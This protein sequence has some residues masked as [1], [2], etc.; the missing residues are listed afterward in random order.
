MKLG[1]QVYE[2]PVWGFIRSVRQ[3]LQGQLKLED[4]SRLD[5]FRKGHEPEHI[6]T[7]DGDRQRSGLGPG[8][9]LSEYEGG[10]LSPGED[11][12]H[13]LIRLTDRH[14]KHVGN[15]CFGA[16]LKLKS[17]S[18]ADRPWL[19]GE[20]EAESAAPL[21]KSRQVFLQTSWKE[22]Y[23][24]LARQLVP[25]VPVSVAV[26]SSHKD[27]AEV[28]RQLKG[29][30][31]TAKVKLH[32]V[33]CQQSASRTQ[34]G[35]EKKL[36]VK[37]FITD[38]ELMGSK[39]DAWIYVM[40][41]EV[42]PGSKDKEASHE[43]KHAR[44]L[45]KGLLKRDRLPLTI[46]HSLPALEPAACME[47]LQI[48]KDSNATVF[49]LPAEGRPAQMIPGTPLSP[50]GH[51]L[52]PWAAPQE[53]VKAAVP[54]L[55]AKVAVNMLV[56]REV[57][58]QL[59][60][61]KN[62]KATTV[63]WVGLSH[64]GLGI[65]VPL[66]PY[67]GIPLLIAESFTRMFYHVLHVCH[68]AGII[69]NLRDAWAILKGAI[70][71]KELEGLKR[72]PKLTK[73]ALEDA[74]KDGGKAG[75]EGAA[76]A[77]FVEI[78]VII[79]KKLASTGAKQVLEQAC[80]A[81]A[82]QVVT[83]V[84]PAI[85]TLLTIAM[86]PHTYHKIHQMVTCLAYTY[87]E[88]WAFIGG[89]RLPMV[90]EKLAMKHPDQAAH[91]PKAMRLEAD[92]DDSSEDLITT[93]WETPPQY[94]AP[95]PYMGGPMYHWESASS[96]ETAPSMQSQG[97][98]SLSA[99]LYGTALAS[100]PSPMSFHL[101]LGL[102]PGVGSTNPSSMNTSFS[103]SDYSGSNHFKATNFGLGG[104]A[105]FQI[106]QQAPYPGAASSS[107]SMRGYLPSDPFAAWAPP[108]T[109]M[110][111]Q[112]FSEGPEPFMGTDIG[113]GAPRSADLSPIIQQEHSIDS[114]FVYMRFQQGAQAGLLLSA[115]S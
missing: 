57:D 79:T 31:D 85:G 15:I 43:L 22:Q 108:A 110:L 89:L 2:W 76:E 24:D 35:K 10:H 14:Q 12:N 91:L 54:C 47:A 93:Q 59:R 103:G 13:H 96:R 86:L 90:Y 69:Y 19:D 88:N 62:P 26:V 66:L 36:S 9:D 37:T 21:N 92:G 45:L 44:A 98:R 58:R 84:F 49:Y 4:S 42:E 111:Q 102:P 71:K 95:L 33:P 115:L 17:R 50:L 105:Y 70:T 25:K 100:Q 75:L 99:G 74:A 32:W 55:H 39:Y 68:T 29:W 112:P 53:A 6:K 3:Q 41:A 8:A 72:N 48:T 78:G 114:A 60:R 38:N 107:G 51:F 81:I 87:H 52:H 34:K 77:I 106:A 104:D 65:L 80:A 83:Y 40:G 113:P 56:R 61:H 67:I 18:S 23:E 73:T 109:D 1:K 101:D 16:K 94:G 64:T 20:L 97:S 63:L 27:T 30:A 5:W 82:S 11:M 7:Q 28:V 46:I